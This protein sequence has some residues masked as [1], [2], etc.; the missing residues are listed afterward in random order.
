[1]WKVES[2]WSKIL[3]HGA[4][5]SIAEKLVTHDAS[6]SGYARSARQGKDSDH[7][8]F[9]CKAEVFGLYWSNCGKF[10]YAI[11]AVIS[12]NIAWHLNLISWTTL[13]IVWAVSI[14]Q[15][16]KQMKIVFIS[17]WVALCGT[18][19]VSVALIFSPDGAL[20]TPTARRSEAEDT[21]TK[22]ELPVPAVTVMPLYRT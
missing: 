5:I 11:C 21:V 14:M 18:I 17:A 13:L 3:R 6:V 12:F 4:F 10:V 22:G 1:L 7:W 19:L 16:W 20:P 2:R 9:S 15:T 8:R